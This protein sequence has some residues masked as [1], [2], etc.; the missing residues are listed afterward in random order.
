MRGRWTRWPTAGGA[1]AT[2]S[3][4]CRLPRIFCAVPR[5]RAAADSIV[6]AAAVACSLFYIFFF[7]G[8]PL[9]AITY[10]MKNLLWRTL[11]G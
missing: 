1:G 7:M 11:R 4:R 10:V 5:T 6:R 3:L 8:M 2:H 9:P